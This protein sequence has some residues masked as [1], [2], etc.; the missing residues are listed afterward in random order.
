VVVDGAVDDHVNVDDHVIKPDR[1]S[2]CGRVVDASSR[3]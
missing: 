2:L 1:S 3:A